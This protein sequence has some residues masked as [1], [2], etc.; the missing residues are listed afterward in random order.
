MHTVAAVTPGGA[1]LRAL[2]VGC[3]PRDVVGSLQQCLDNAILV[4]DRVSMNRSPDGAISGRRP[5][6]LMRH[7]SIPWD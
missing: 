3:L 1:P 4:Q 2:P 5:S 6:G 7:F